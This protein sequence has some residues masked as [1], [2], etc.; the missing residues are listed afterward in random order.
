VSYKR[1]QVGV[2]RVY[3][4]KPRSTLLETVNFLTDNVSLQSVTGGLI[5]AESIEAARKAIRKIVKR[6]ASLIIRVKAFLPRTRKPSEVRMGKGKGKINHYVAVVRPGHV[7]FEIS[8][9][10]TGSTAA[11]A[12]QRAASKLSIQTRILNLKDR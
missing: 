1:K 11:R 10:V 3:L 9:N 7:L 8:G 2:R 5:S 4:V 6:T 12:L